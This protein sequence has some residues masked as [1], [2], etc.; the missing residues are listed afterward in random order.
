MLLLYALVFV[1]KDKNGKAQL[2]LLDHGL[3][4]YLSDR[5]RVRLCHLYKAIIHRDEAMM[6]HYSSQLGVTG[7]IEYNTTVFDIVL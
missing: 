1:R 2:V 3:Y 5:D 6:K 7:R 4:D